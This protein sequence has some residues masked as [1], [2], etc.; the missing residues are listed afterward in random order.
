M[1]A[2]ILDGNQ[3]AA[4]R[5]VRL[6][7]EVTSE[8]TLGVIVATGN[9]AVLAYDAAKRRAAEEVGM[10]FVLRDLGPTASRDDLLEAC[11]DFDAD[12][13]ITGY[14]VQTPL[15]S[16]IDRR[17]IFAAIHPN[18]DA[19]G[20]AP[21]NLANLFIDR[22]AIVPAT[23][24]GILSLLEHTGVT[25][26]GA[27]VTVIGK[28]L[29]VGQPVATLLSHR[30]ATV[31]SCDKATVDLASHTTGADIL[32]VAAG[33]PGLVNGEMVKDGAVVIDVGI[34]RVDGNLTGDVDFAAAA[35]KAAWITP[36]PGGVG[37][38][39]VVSLLEN[40]VALSKLPHKIH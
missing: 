32:I 27:A 18:K 10:A 20:L 11:A 31:T 14:L 12:P 28:S 30:G 13:T 1:P 25:I 7:Q 24:K 3:I 36:V 2:K 33:H 23:P 9:P 40:V 38:M 15:P 34:T 37:P 17:D 4:E 19:D 26:S 39:T 22:A 21:A 16:G 6:V 35:A 8:L 5:R 29:L